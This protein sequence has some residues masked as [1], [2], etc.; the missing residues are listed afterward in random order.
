MNLKSISKFQ[1]I[2]VSFFNS[3]FVNIL[4]TAKIIRSS[5]ILWACC[6]V[7]L[8]YT[9]VKGA[10]SVPEESPSE[11]FKIRPEYLISQFLEK[12]FSSLVEF[13]S[14]V[15]EDSKPVAQKTSS[16][17]TSYAEKW[18]SNDSFDE[19]LHYGAFFALSFLVAGLYIVPIMLCCWVVMWLIGWAYYYVTIHF[20]WV[21]FY[22]FLTNHRKSRPLWRKA[23]Q[24]DNR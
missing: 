18:V 24:E 16:K 4:T 9:P 22:T 2:L 3:R 7:V 11:S 6:L 13:Y 14:P 12:N 10:M 17:R 21:V 5:F 1:Q 15:F 8:S 23:T 19:L 20:D